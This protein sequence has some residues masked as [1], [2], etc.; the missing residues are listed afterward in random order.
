MPPRL[1]VLDLHRVEI[2]PSPSVGMQLK[3]LAALYFSAMDCGLS[4][5][6]R[7][8]FLK[9]YAGLHTRRSLKQALVEDAGLFQAVESRAQR[10]YRKFQ[11]KVQ[12]GISM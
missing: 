12:A 2:K 11:R 1:H 9:H 7:L 10:L 3:D 6:D 8:Y 5:G 4:R